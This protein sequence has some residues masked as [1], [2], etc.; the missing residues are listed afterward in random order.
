VPGVPDADGWRE[1][2]AYHWLVL[3]IIHNNI[4]IIEA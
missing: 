3:L 2:L 1:A 4:W